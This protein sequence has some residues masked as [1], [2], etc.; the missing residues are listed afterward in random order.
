MGPY[1]QMSIAMKF[2]SERKKISHVKQSRKA[3]V[4]QSICQV[5]GAFVE[6]IGNLPL[7]GSAELLQGSELQC[8]A[9]IET[10]FL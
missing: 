8:C 2:L 9:H 4:K 3:T 10:G 5:W 7:T 1:R 6:V